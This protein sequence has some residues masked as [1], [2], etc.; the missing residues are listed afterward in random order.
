MSEA[1]DKKDIGKIDF[2]SLKS[3]ALEMHG[4]KVLPGTS[5]AELTSMLEGQGEDLNLLYEKIASMNAAKKRTVKVHDGKPT[6]GSGAKVVL[7]HVFAKDPVDAFNVIDTVMIY[8][9]EKDNKPVY[10]AVNNRNATVPR[11]KEMPIRR[12]L[13][14]AL[15]NAIEESMNPETKE[16]TSRPRFPH[17]VIQ[18]DVSGTGPEA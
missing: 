9:D 16:K 14:L 4:M 15:A 8:E 10:V 3:Y 13:R 18:Y 2:N 11:G 5:R 6:P 17:T 7:G 1:K 12:P